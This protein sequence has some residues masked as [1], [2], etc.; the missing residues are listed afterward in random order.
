MER[1]AFFLDRD[2][3]INIDRVYIND[4]RLMEL[5]PGAAAAIGRVRRAGF[6]VVVVTNQSGIGRGIIEPGALPRIH[7]RM[8]ELL[9]AEDPDAL[10]DRYEICVHAPVENCDCRKPSPKMVLEASRQMGVDLN[11]SVFIGDKLTDVGCGRQ[12]GCRFSI[13]LRSGKGEEEEKLLKRGVSA[14]E[15]PDFVADDLTEAVSWALERLT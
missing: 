5:I 14:S 8:E 15:T 7:A 3:T 4:P 11:R 6:A 9:K 12:A 1:G 13:L 10:I 2:G